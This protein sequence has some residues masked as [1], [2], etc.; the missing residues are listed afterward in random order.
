[1]RS[2]LVSGEASESSAHDCFFLKSIRPRSAF[3]EANKGGHV[4]DCTIA[5]VYRDQVRLHSKANEEPR[6]SQGLFREQ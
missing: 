1:V 5:I 3:G 2:D 6:I 4:Q